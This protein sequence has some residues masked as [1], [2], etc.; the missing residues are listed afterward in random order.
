MTDLTRRFRALHA[1]GCFIVP[2]PWDTTS[3][4]LL[5]RCGFKALA[6][7]SS[8][9][10]F[11][12]DRKDGH[13]QV[14]REEAIRHAVSLMTA[15]GLPVTLDAEDC[16][17][18]SAEGVART[19][20]MAAEAGLAGISIEDRDTSNPGRMRD[21]DEALDRVQAAASRAK[22]SGIVLTARADGLGKAAYDFHETMRRLL[23]YAE[24][25][26][27]VVYAPGLPTLAAIQ[28][29]CASVPA[30]VN[31]V[32]GQGAR[33]LSL[34]ALAEAGVRRIS[35]GGSF[36]RAALGAVAGIARTIAAGDFSSIDAAPGW[37]ELR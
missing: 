3:A 11:A 17:E 19:V 34:E 12:T 4:R 5:A 32:L 15:T 1:S 14:T 2:N 28:H 29:V 36:A 35:L 30:P 6:S 8:G 26:A 10:A 18:D 7:T 13:R 27:D 20:E 37:S 33:G 23:A 24:A 9:Y 22:D 21:F 31:H 25:G 16:Y